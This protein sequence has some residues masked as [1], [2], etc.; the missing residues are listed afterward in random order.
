MKGLPFV[1]GVP[2]CSFQSPYTEYTSPIRGGGACTAGRAV[3]SQKEK[4][5]PGRTL[6]GS[7][8][9]L[10]VEC[11]ELQARLPGRGDAADRAVS[12]RFRSV[13]LFQVPLHRRDPEVSLPSSLRSPT[14]RTIAAGHYAHRLAIVKSAAGF[15]VDSISEVYGHGS[16][17]GAE[18]E[19]SSSPSRGSGVSE[20]S[21]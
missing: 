17:D 13:E 2:R 11:L 3:L 16:G 14:A 10:S 5:L 21:P 1:A 19:P 12:Q 15:D 4:S 7:L 18:A 9:R 20:L 8:V 6:E